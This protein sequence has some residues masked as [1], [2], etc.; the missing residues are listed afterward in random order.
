SDGKIWVGNGNGIYIINPDNFRIESFRDH[1]LL[2]KL[3]GVRVNSFM[4]DRKGNIWMATFN[5]L[6]RY[7]AKKNTLV[8]FTEREGLGTRYCFNLFE[9]DR[10]NIYTGTSKGFSIITPDS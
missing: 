7:N 4:E 3:D 2:K 1:P 5:G 8:N 10:G 6:Y 9:D